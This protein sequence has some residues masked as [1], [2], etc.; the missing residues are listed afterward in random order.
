MLSS[1]LRNGSA[2]SEIRRRLLVDDFVCVENDDDAI[3]DVESRFD[4]D[5]RILFFFFKLI[6]LG[7]FSASLFGLSPIIPE[8]RG[9][10]QKHEVFLLSMN[11][12][13]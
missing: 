8:H 11:S 13:L 6:P 3:D 5:R 7:F 4:C 1:K 12:I 2:V 9:E 10:S